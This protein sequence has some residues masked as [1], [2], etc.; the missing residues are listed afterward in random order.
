MFNNSE[1]NPCFD[2]FG[3]TLPTRFS[4]EQFYFLK[5]YSTP[6]N[7]NSLENINNFWNDIEVYQENSDNTYKNTY[8]FK[9]DKEGCQ[10]IF[11]V[12]EVEDYICSSI[13]NE[14]DKEK[15]HTDN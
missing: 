10:M 6:I 9:T 12:L 14:K 1:V 3:T 7:L 15:L 2:K 13:T 4:A 11:C 5:Q 8:I